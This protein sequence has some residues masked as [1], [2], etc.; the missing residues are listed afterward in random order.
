M[1]NIYARIL[2]ATMSDCPMCDAELQR[3]AI[4]CPTCGHR[5]EEQH[6]EKKEQNQQILIALGLLVILALIFIL[7]S[8]DFQVLGF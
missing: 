7:Y 1:D 8:I 2:E 5:L 6:G 4:S 3:G